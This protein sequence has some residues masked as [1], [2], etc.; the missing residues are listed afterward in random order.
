MAKRVMA[1]FELVKGG[2]EI[3]QSAIYT[4]KLDVAG[5][6]KPIEIDKADLIDRANP[7]KANGTNNYRFKSVVPVPVMAP[8]TTNQ[9][10]V[11]QIG[12]L[13]AMIDQYDA[14]DQIKTTDGRL[15]DRKVHIVPRKV[16][17]DGSIS[18]EPAMSTA[19]YLAMLVRNAMRLDVQ[20]DMQAPLR[21]EA[22]KVIREEKSLPAPAT[23]VRARKTK[24]GSVYD[25]ESELA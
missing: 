13:A 9:E 17:D 25:P 12:R 5:S 22:E 8:V 4:L 1:I 19:A 11:D 15:I 14:A 23:K 6:D 2:F 18:T 20:K 24:D 21:S 7:V 16:N 3:V 10:L